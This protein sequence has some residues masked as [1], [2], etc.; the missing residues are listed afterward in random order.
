MRRPD[1]PPL[2]EAAAAVLA[3]DGLNE[4]G[5]CLVTLAKWLD[6]EQRI[7]N[8]VDF[9]GVRQALGTHY[10]DSGDCALL[11]DPQYAEVIRDEITKQV[12]AMDRR[13]LLHLIQ[14]YHEALVGAQAMAY[15]HNE[16]IEKTRALL[17]S[18]GQPT[19]HLNEM[20]IRI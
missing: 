3:G 12:T 18:V 14:V 16:S 11:D 13:Y 19:G 15:K 4:G 9:S 1:F 5:R 17:E 10:R 20:F 2:L 7:A 8:S 6:L